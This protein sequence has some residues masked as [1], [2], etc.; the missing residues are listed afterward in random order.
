M[1]GGPIDTRKPA[2][3]GSDAAEQGAALWAFRCS[4]RLFPRPP[5][6]RPGLARAEQ[7]PRVNVETS[8]PSISWRPPTSRD[9][10]EPASADRVAVAVESW[11]E[12]ESLLMGLNGV[13]ARQ[14][15]ILSFPAT[16][17]RDDGP[18]VK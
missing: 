16:V 11:A 5:C 15:S 9:P 1:P 13:R 14:E 2:V 8:L 7:S 4:G 6:R 17:P 3:D 12:S 10:G 18:N